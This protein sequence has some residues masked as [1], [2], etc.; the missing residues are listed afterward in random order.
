M[1]PRSCLRDAKTHL[2]LSLSADPQVV[3]ARLGSTA[4]L[5]CE[6]SH[7]SKP[8]VYVQWRTDSAVV[9][10]RTRRDSYQGERYKGRVDVPEKQLLEG[11]CS[12][13]LKNVYINDAGV[14]Y[15]Y[16][17]MKHRKRS[18]ARF[19]QRVELE[20]YGKCFNYSTV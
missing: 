3:S 12:L 9:F 5:P 13:V 18:V 14:Y 17:V 4:V 7:A 16:L 10:E 20:V 6:P 8:T 1:I 11:N 2:D 15:S 19:I